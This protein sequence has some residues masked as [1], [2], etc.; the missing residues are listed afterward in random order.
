MVFWIRD[1][2]WDGMGWD[3][4]YVASLLGDGTSHL[5]IEGMFPY[6]VG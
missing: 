1:L 3:G 5:M 4:C 6:Y 2:D